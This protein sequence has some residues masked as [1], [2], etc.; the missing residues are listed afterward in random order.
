MGIFVIQTIHVTS[1]LNTSG[2]FENPLCGTKIYIILVKN[3]VLYGMKYIYYCFSLM[4]YKISS[5]FVFFW[6]KFN[7]FRTIILNNVLKKYFDLYLF[8]SLNEYVF[9][10]FL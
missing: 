10:I 6:D 2:L 5:W 7:L 4:L 8:L 3:Y 9:R 1:F